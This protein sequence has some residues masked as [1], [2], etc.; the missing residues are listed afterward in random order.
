[1]PIHAVVFDVGGVILHERDH[2][3]RSEWE[4]RLGLPPGQLTRLVL[5][6]EP[7]AHAAAGQVAERQV[8][9]AVGEQLG[10]DEVHI[11]ELQRDFWA[12]EQLDI[13]MVRFIQALRPQYKV[14]ILSNAW[15]DA[16]SFH[17][18]KFKL[19]TWVDVQVYSAEVK[20]LKPDPRIYQI[21][22]DQLSLPASACVFVDDRPENVQAAQSLGMKGVLCRDTQQAIDDIQAYLVD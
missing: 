4:T 14:G 13:T 21:V 8:W 10:L 3:K 15:S 17:N 18:I 12:G 20:L 9:Q 2:A 19:N 7:A 11:L 16:R 22:L 5:D 1:M 6:S